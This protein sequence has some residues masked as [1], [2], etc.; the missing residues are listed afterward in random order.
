MTKNLLKR[1]N[2]NILFSQRSLS[3]F[4]TRSKLM[5]RTFWG[6]RHVCSYEVLQLT[7]QPV[8]PVQPSPD[9]LIPTV[10]HAGG[11][12]PWGSFR[13]RAWRVHQDWGRCRTKHT[14]LLN[15]TW[16]WVFRT[17]HCPKGSSPSWTM[18][19]DT[20]KHRLWDNLVNFLECSNPSPDMNQIKAL[21]NLQRRTTEN[22]QIQLSRAG[23]VMSAGSGLWS[24]ALSEYLNQGQRH[25]PV[26]PSEESSDEGKHNTMWKV[27]NL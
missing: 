3:C 14:D 20:V 4:N 10:G 24:G 22:L 19:L 13:V 23:C 25:I 15:E 2:W 21:E 12:M 27:V 8:Q 9:H 17:S 5:D 11:F 1:K 6:K 26:F 7:V 16:S 18:T